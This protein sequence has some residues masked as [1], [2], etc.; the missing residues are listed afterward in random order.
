[1]R[2][3]D[4]N[5][6]DLETLIQLADSKGG[7]FTIFRFTTHWKCAYGTPDLDSVPGEEAGFTAGYEEVRRMP[8]YP[9]LK[10]AVVAMILGRTPP[11]R[12]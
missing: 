5:V 11:L 12:G 2:P 10:E 4:L 7:H 8:H 1:M 3:L 6:L 9:T